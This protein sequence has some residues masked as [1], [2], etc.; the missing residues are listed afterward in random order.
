MTTTF[1][2]MIYSNFRAL[3][4]ATFYLKFYS[5][6]KGAPFYSSSSELQQDL[7]HKRADE[8]RQVAKRLV[9]TAMMCD[10]KITFIRL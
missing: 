8:E 7:H 9:L 10:S 6:L 2:R 3:I 5:T 1:Q 4:H